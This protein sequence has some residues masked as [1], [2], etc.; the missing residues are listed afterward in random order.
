L[1]EAREGG[2]EEVELLLREWLSKREQKGM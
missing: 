1:R 2:H